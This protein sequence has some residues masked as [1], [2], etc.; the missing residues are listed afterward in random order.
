MYGGQSGPAAVEALAEEVLI[1]IHQ[2]ISAADATVA[3]AS[4]DVHEVPRKRL[5]D[6]I[7]TRPENR[8][9]TV[10]NAA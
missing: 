9:K 4:N 3:M 8:C 7:V 1:V 10:H 5:Q 6:V 2:V